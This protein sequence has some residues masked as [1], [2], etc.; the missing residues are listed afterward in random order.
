[1]TLDVCLID[2]EVFAKLKNKPG[3]G[4]RRAGEKQIKGVSGDITTARG[5]A[6]L[7]LTFSND[8]GTITQTQTVHVVKD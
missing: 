6:D 3:V 5:C 8:K 2:A 4:E 7:V 1:M